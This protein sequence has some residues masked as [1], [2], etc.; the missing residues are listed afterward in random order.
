MTSKKLSRKALTIATTILVTIALVYA[1]WPQPTRVDIGTVSQG[2]MQVTINEE[3]HTR[4]TELYVLSAPVSGRLLRLELKPGAAVVQGKTLVAQLL[5]NPLDSHEITQGQAR[6]QAAEAAVD[7]AQA[8]LK[9]AENDQYLADQQAR[10]NEQQARLG[11]L[12]VA[13]NEQTQV[14]ADNAAAAV[15]SAVA[16]LAMRRAELLNARAALAGSG[17]DAPFKAIDILAPISG[18][19]LR[20]MEENEKVVTAGV[21]IV[22]IGDVTHGLEVE[23][24]LLSRDA[25]QIRPG[26]PVQI[27]NWGGDEIIAGVVSRID[28]LGYIKTSALGVEERR[29]KA[30]ISLPSLPVSASGLGHGFRVD[31]AIVVWQKTSAV[32]V[33]SSALLRENG[34]WAVFVV[35][36]GKAQLR[37]LRIEKNNGTEASVLQGLQ[38]NEKVILYPAAELG[39]GMAVEQR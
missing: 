18:K 22:E 8:A 33:P 15:A 29:V 36:N 17:G 37:T 1:F 30:L 11:A 7:A 26:Q 6:V 10:R 24:E 2:P 27:S 13:D 38:V 16:M 20:V 32:K 35:D 5:P 14:K 4:V 39:D 12:S 28:P 3:A 9:Q 19:I 25:V 21:A 23:V 34:D 31:V